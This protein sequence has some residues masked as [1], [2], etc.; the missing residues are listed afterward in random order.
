MVGFVGEL[1]C[2]VLPKLA[3]QV[4]VIV[5]LSKR[6]ML[7]YHILSNHAIS[8]SRA[9]SHFID[10]SSETCPSGLWPLRPPAL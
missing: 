4:Q 9:R 7:S 2:V 6:P 8:V 5:Q 1:D 10:V 3:A